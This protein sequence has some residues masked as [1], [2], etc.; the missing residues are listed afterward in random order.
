MDEKNREIRLR[1]WLNQAES[2]ALAKITAAKGIGA[3]DLI[4]E[5][6]RQNAPK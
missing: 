2:D 5:Y 6:I 4:R 1:I 3:A